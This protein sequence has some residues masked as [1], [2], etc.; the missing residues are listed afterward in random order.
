MSELYKHKSIKTGFVVL[1][2]EANHGH[3]KTTVGSIKQNYPSSASLV[4]APSHA[5]AS[6]LAEMA[7]FTTAIRGGDT[8][9][10]LINLGM[11]ETTCEEWNF[12]VMAG[13]WV[14][15][16]LDR[17]YG[18][19]IEN[20]QDILFPI[21]NRQMNFIDATINGIL[22]HKKTFQAIGPL[23]EKCPIDVCKL[24]WAMNAADKGCRFK[25]VL[26]TR[27]C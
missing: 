25:A 1:A 7:R 23:D 4:V 13:G 18:Y 17:K 14:R 26:G 3:V 20:D 15:P 8:I 2:T 27:V 21:I 9:T 11:K 10:S 5:R 19:F 24:F 22:V 16:L 6:D 12:I